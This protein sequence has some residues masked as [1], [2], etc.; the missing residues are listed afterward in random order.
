MTVQDLINEIRFITKTDST[1]F[2]DAEIIAGLNLHNAE[3]IQDIIRVQTTRN[4]T[5]TNVRYDLISTGGLS[6]GN[7]GYNGEYPFPTDLLRPI[8]VEVSFDGASWRPCEVYDINGNSTSEYNQTEIN[9]AWMTT[10]NIGTTPTAVTPY[11]RFM[12]DSFFIRPLNTNSTV[13]N[14]LVVWYEARQED[15]SLTTDSPV[16][17]SNFH[18]ILVFKGALRY[19]MRYAEKYNP[20]WQTKANEIKTYM[21]EWYKNRFKSNMKIKP[22]YERFM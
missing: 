18:E 1:S 13:S 2:T 7:I 3:I 14:G 17:E 12:R 22:S 15:L 10:E 8:R 20:L 9:Q 6:E 5:A 4:T 21:M 11:V 19:A 16:F